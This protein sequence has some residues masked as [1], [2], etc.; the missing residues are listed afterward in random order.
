MLP[1]STQQ[2]TQR[3]TM[4]LGGRTHEIRRLIGRS[5]RAAVNLEKL[6]PRTCLLDCDVLQADGGTRTAAITGG[7]AALVIALRKLIQNDV[8]PADT[9]KTAVAAVSVGMINGESLLDLCYIEDSS[10]EVDANI[11]MTGQ[12]S[13][14]EVQSTA[15]GNIFSRSDLDQMLNLASYGIEQLLAAQKAVLG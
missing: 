6:G 4:G 11:V 7:Y 15:E 2:R 5:L 14:V 13:F 10:A 12:G 8:I 9:I 3:E 1:R